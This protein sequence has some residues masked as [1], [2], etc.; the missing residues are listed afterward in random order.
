M[1]R[2]KRLRLFVGRFAQD[3]RNTAAR[4]KINLGTISLIAD[5]LYGA[6]WVDGSI[7]S[8]ETIKCNGYRKA[9]IPSLTPWGLRPCVPTPAE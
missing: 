9:L 7:I 4:Q 8:F 2:W 6:G 3:A 1:E 5:L